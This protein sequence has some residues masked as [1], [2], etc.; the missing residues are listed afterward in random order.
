MNKLIEYENGLKV[1]VYNMPGV[2]SVSCGY[3]VGVGSG[4]ET[5]DINGL[6]HFTEHMMFKG[7]KDMTPFDIANAFESY[8]ANVNAFTS[9]ECTCYYVK[10]VD[11]SE[12]IFVIGSNE[13]YRR[14]ISFYAFQRGSI[15]QSFGN[16][17]A[18][19]S[20]FGYFCNSC[21]NLFTKS[22]FLYILFCQ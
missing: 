12:G 10:S 13:E 4:S 9:K 17:M 15:S 19:T 20:I 7:T 14:D 18:V 16:P 1:V 22:L 3:W 2:R 8:G 21:L 5:A 11:G 6:S